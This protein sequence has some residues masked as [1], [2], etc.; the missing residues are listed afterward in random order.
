[1]YWGVA[2]INVSTYLTRRDKRSRD[3]GKLL[4]SPYP[5]RG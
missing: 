3:I 4:R 2:V 1:M 5:K